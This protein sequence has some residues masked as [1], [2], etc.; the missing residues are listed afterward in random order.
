MRIYSK[1]GLEVYDHLSE[2]NLDPW[3]IIYQ[4]YVN[5]KQLRKNQSRNNK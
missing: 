3:Y 5:P 2:I 4:N 1:K